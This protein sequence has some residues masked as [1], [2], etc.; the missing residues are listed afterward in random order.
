[1]G[2]RSHEA[3]VVTVG[4]RSAEIDL[5]LVDLIKALWTL[6]IDTLFSCQGQ[7]GP[8]HDPQP[9]PWG[10]ILFPDI[11][12]LR[13]FLECFDGTVLSGRRFEQ[14]HEWNPATGTRTPVGPPRWKIGATVRPPED[15][16]VLEPDA[17][18]FHFRGRIGFLQA[19]IREMTRIVQERAESE[20]QMAVGDASTGK[21]GTR[22]AT[23]GHGKF[24]HSTCGG[25]PSD[26]GDSG[27]R[28][29]DRQGHRT[30]R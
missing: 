13:A 12:D 28:S 19:D 9:E 26:P 18:E 24:R 2:V 30:P 7:Y 4:E 16:E 1:V 15:D 14:R 25:N 8:A 23:L 27:R 17:P 21:V 22:A 10:Y 11:E 5:E 3:R 20:I 29:N 6:G